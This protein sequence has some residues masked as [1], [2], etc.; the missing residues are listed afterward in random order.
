MWFKSN[1][2]IAELEK[3]LAEVVE[4]CKMN[5]K[6]SLDIVQ[7]YAKRFEELEARLKKLEVKCKKTSTP[8]S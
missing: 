8:K 3:A 7:D 1:K 4:N 5:G 6:L 2:R